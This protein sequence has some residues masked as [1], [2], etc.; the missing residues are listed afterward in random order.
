MTSIIFWLRFLKYATTS[1]MSI[2]SKHYLQYLAVLRIIYFCL[3]PFIFCLSPSYVASSPSLAVAPSLVAPSPRRPVAPSPHAGRLHR[4]KGM[5]H[6]AWSM[7]K[8]SSI[9]DYLLLSFA[10]C[11]LPFVFSLLTSPRRPVAPSPGRTV[12]WSH[13]R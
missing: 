11:L 2:K 5:G 4:A 3:L 13:G 9:K 12:A 10:F 8:K 7:G 6:G 1:N